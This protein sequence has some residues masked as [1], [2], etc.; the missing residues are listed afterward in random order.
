MLRQRRLAFSLLVL[1]ALAASGAVPPPARAVTG[2]KACG[3]VAVYV[4][5]TALLPGALTVGSTPFVIAVGKTLDSSVAVGANLC[6]DLMLNLGGEV[7]DATV[8]TN[9]SST[10]ALCGRV[11]TYTAATATAAG[12]LT[13]NGV[14]SVV[15][16]G[17]SLPASVNVGADLCM[18]LT[19]NGLRQVSAATVQ[20]NVISTMDIC[21]PVTAYAAATVRSTG[22]LTV[23]GRTFV[24]AVGTSLPASVHVGANLC[25]HLMRNGFGQVSDGTAQANVTS[26]LEVCGRVT[27]YAAATSTSTGSITIDR[28]SRAVA[29]GTSLSSSIN[30]NAYLKLRLTLDAYLR[31][32]DA[33]VLKVGVS[34]SDVCGS[35][36]IPIPTP[37]SGAPPPTSATLDASGGPYPSGSPVPNVQLDAS[38]EPQATAG[39]KGGRSNVGVSDDPKTAVAASTDAGQIVPDTASL[40]RAGMA[41]LQVSL[42]LLLLLAGLITREL[43]LRRRRLVSPAPNHDVNAPEA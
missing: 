42:P 38:D 11:T 15:A 10:L 18:R 23:A 41:V 13:I 43:V 20:A 35:S 36:T 22:S 1:M 14:S 28:T 27:A 30:V 16:V 2:V 5:A 31:I 29:A 12:S 3:P 9:V 33:A 24:V 37:T 17:T 21:G 8:T 34:L 26:T 19:L 4:P 40:G 32:T 39:S 7:T 25:M 6:F